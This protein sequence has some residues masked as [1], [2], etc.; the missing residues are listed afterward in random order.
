MTKSSAPMTAADLM[1]RDVVTVPQSVPA[2]EAARLLVSRAIGG[3]PVVD[4]QGRCVGVFSAADFA[5]IS[6]AYSGP[7][8]PPVPC[9]F[10]LRHRRVDGSDIV[11]CSLPGGLCPLQR[12]ET[13]E[14]HDQCVC[15]Y[16]QEI[17]VEWQSLKPACSP[18]N[19]VQDWMTADPITV[20][21]GVSLA[22]CAS[23]MLQA[24]IH[25]LIVVDDERRVI[26]LLSS[27]D[28]LNAIA[29]SPTSP[30]ASPVAAGGDRRPRSGSSR[31][32]SSS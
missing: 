7:T 9:P 6:Q 17:V 13:E 12:M 8:R 29:R 24:R 21:A 31:S 16:P 4:D 1:T 22:E 5:R 11:L 26:G 20:T 3:V 14:G 32:K 19:P 10:Q 28:L 18:S 15:S 27:T 30:S 23:R 25:R 2:S